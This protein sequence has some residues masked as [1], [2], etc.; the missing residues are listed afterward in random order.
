M[1]VSIGGLSLTGFRTFEPVL[2][3]FTGTGYVQR[4]PV[5]PIPYRSSLPPPGSTSAF[6]A[7]EAAVWADQ[8]TKNIERL[9]QL[10]TGW[11]GPRSLPI[12][13]SLLNRVSG[14]IRLALAPLGRDA[15]A[16]FVVPLPSGGVQVEWHTVRGE[17][18]CELAANG[19]A[20]VW[21]KDHGSAYEFETEGAQAVNQF[22]LWA[23]RLAQEQ[24]DVAN[25]QA[26]KT[27]PIFAIAA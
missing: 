18:E 11:D 22:L 10:T 19:T 1:S 15:R 27:S 16:P 20:S 23:P 4:T 14:L 7:A 25:V 8:L 13:H 17:L 9:R 3:M 12:D 24:L 21:I 2:P 26:A 6:P 5:S